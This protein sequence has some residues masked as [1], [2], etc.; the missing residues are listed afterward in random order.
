MLNLLAVFAIS[1]LLSIVGH[2]RLARQSVASVQ[3]ED[4]RQ[5][6]ATMNSVTEAMKSLQTFDAKMAVSP[7]STE[8]PDAHLRTNRTPEP[9]EL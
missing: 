2:A 9:T 4:V 3:F 8:E 6:T 5:L 7:E 1:H